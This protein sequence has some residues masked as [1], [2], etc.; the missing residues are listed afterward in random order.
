MNLYLQQLSSFSKFL[1]WLP[2]PT[3]KAR[4]HFNPHHKLLHDVP[5]KNSLEVFHDC[6]Y[7][8]EIVMLFCRLLA[9]LSSF[10]H[11]LGLVSNIVPRKR[12]ILRLFLIFS[13]SARDSEAKGLSYLFFWAVTCESWILAKAMRRFTGSACI[14]LH[15]RNESWPHSS[16]A[17]FKSKYGHILPQLSQLGGIFAS[18]FSSSLLASTF[19][20][21][22]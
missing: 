13:W 1:S 6:H 16:S 19:F 17:I 15:V 22:L 3:S 12:V 10:A 4:I 18:A 2:I 5:P 21:S 7:G 20:K 11:C 9:L 8:R 14:L